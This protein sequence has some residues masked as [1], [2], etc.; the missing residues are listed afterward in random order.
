MLK[1]GLKLSD[2]QASGS[3][4]IASPAAAG[5]DGSW[6][7]PACGNMNFPGRM[8]CNKRSCGRPRAG[9]GAS[10]PFMGGAAGAGAPPDSWVCLACRNVNFPT[11][12]ECNARNCGKP[13]AQVDGGP[14]PGGWRGASAAGSGDVYPPDSWVCLACQNVN[15]PTRTECNARG[16]GQPR[17]HVDGGAPALRSA[18]GVAVPPD[19]WV[20][21]SCQ[22]VNFPTRTECNARGCGKPRAQVDGGPPQASDG[23]VGSWVCPACNNVNYANRTSC[24]KRTCGLPRPA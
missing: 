11:R 5:M 7:C 20:C 15:Y 6:A 22:N 8:V 10:L 13:R 12:T 18:N 3:A 14:P 16:C 24:N 23:L 1:P 4:S 19:S 21:L 17:A 9:V 2:L